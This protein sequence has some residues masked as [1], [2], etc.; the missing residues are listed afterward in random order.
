M[1]VHLNYALS[2]LAEPLADLSV[3]PLLGSAFGKI[4]TELSDSVSNDVGAAG[5][6]AS[7]AI[8]PFSDGQPVSVG[9]SATTELQILSQ[10]LIQAT[11]A[12]HHVQQW[13]VSVEDFAKKL[14]ILRRVVEDVSPQKALAMSMWMFQLVALVIAIAALIL[15]SAL[16]ADYH[17]RKQRREAK[18]RGFHRPFY[19][20]LFLSDE[21]ST[22]MTHSVKP[23]RRQHC[24][25]G[26]IAS[27]KSGSMMSTTIWTTHRSVYQRKRSSFSSRSVATASTCTSPASTMIPLKEAIEEED[28]V[29][30]VSSIGLYHPVDEHIRRLEGA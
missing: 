1:N 23:R 20:E 26:S 28:A 18:I 21:V 27:R 19:E 30:T 2:A 5:V 14:P 15:I 17:M 12:N 13:P 22:Y 16:Y 11:S 10:D 24:S 3:T 4:L 8:F 25:G 7:S 6:P 9:S 29:S